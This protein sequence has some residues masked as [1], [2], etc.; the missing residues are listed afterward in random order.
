MKSIFVSMMAVLLG[1]AFAVAPP[2][3]KAVTPVDCSNTSC[4]VTT[5]DSKVCTV[6]LCENGVCSI[7]GSYPNPDPHPTKHASIVTNQGPLPPSGEC[8]VSGNE[9]CAIQFCAN[10][11]CTISLYDKKS[12]SFVPIGEVEDA[13]KAIDKMINNAN[14][15]LNPHNR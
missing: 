13:G 15:T 10:G 8:D 1:F 7:V 6:Y 3:A 11:T 4:K 9:P 14:S 12:R 2:P 5:C